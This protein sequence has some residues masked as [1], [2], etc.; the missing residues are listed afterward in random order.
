MP[1]GARAVSQLPPAIKR[2]MEGVFPLSLQG[3]KAQIK[4]QGDLFLLKMGL[5]HHPSERGEQAIGIEI[6]AFEADQDAVLMGVAA[7]P[8]TAAL[9]EVGQFQ[10]IQR[11]AAPAEHRPQQLMAS[12]LAGWITAAA[13][14]DPE[15]CRQHPCGAHRVEDEITA[16]THATSSGRAIRVNPRSG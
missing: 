12:T 5:A 14:T 6:P 15:F 16:G 2:A 1:I 3:L 13:A 4:L 11:A 7:K 10:M 8:C 9:H